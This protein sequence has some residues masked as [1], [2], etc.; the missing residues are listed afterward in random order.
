MSE[1]SAGFTDPRRVQIPECYITLT[2]RREDVIH[3]GY[4]WNSS[5]SMNFTILF[6][7]PP[8][9]SG[10][11]RIGI[12]AQRRGIRSGTLQIYIPAMKEQQLLRTPMLLCESSS[13]YQNSRRNGEEDQSKD[14]QYSFAF[15]IYE[16]RGQKA[17]GEK[18]YDYSDTHQYIYAALC[19]HASGEPFHVPVMDGPRASTG[20]PL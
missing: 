11:F 10:R 9:D 3:S 1:S 18:H 13:C 15:R 5:P 16:S 19:C 17:G 14:S 4:S 12:W 8:S 6:K 2:C 20:I 7:L